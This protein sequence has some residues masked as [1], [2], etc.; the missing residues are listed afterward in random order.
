MTAATT[1]VAGSYYFT[2][3]F[4][5]ATSSIATLTVAAAV[6]TTYTVTYNGNGNTSGTAPVDST[7]YKTGDTVTVLANSSSLSRTGSSTAGLVHPKVMK[8]SSTTYFFIGWSTSATGTVTYVPGQTFVMGSAN[9]TLYAVWSTAPAAPSITSSETTITAYDTVTVTITC[10]TTGAS[11]YYT[12]DGS[13]PTT[14]S[15]LYS[16]PFTFVANFDP[17]LTPEII[18]AI[19]VMSG[20]DSATTT[21]SYTW[22]W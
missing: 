9:V 1:A 13:I 3:A 22:G 15:T 14:S 18:S 4:G 17:S 16:T 10:P 20:T 7:L 2:V 21:V 5:S 12:T 19:A 11:I 8:P 6:V